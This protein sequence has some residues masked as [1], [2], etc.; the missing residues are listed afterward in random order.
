VQG[1]WKWYVSC[2]GAIGCQDVNNTFVNIK[3]D[4]YVVDYEDGSQQTFYFTWK[5][6][7][8]T[9]NGHETYVMWNEE[10]NK[11][12]WCF[13]SI[14]NDTLTAVTFD[15]PFSFGFVRVK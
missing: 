3:E 2:G 8:P 5:K 1:K 15:V 6:Y 7:D 11:A 10:N 13:V 9:S 14:K 12:G 4:H